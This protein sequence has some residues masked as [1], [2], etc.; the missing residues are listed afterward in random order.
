MSAP[1]SLILPTRDAARHLPAALD[2]LLE[3]VWEGLVRE[4]IVADGGSTDDTFDIAEAAGA[5]WL[6]GPASRPERVAAAVAAARAPWLLF[7]EPEARLAPGWTGAVKAALARPQSAHHFRLR[8]DT[9]A[10][11]PALIARFANWRGRRLGLPF[12]DQGLLVRRALLGTADLSLDD[13][14]L[15]RALSGRHRQAEAEVILPVAP[16]RA[17]G[18]VRQGAR[19]LRH[20][21]RLLAAPR[22]AEARR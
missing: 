17:R 7:L 8:F 13:L 5:V 15:T 11:G 21:A 2:S 18:W 3:G 16:Y 12:P 9:D 4:L 6:P 19:N 1:L 14:A 20:T 10:P 22:P